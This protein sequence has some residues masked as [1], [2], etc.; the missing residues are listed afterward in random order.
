MPPSTAHF[1]HYDRS[2]VNAKPNGKLNAILGL[3]AGVQL[4]HGLDNPQTCLHCPVRIVFVC[5]GIAKV[6][7]KPVTEILCYVAVKALN[8]IC[9]LFLVGPHNLAKVFGVESGGQ[10]GR[11]NQIAKHHG[12]LTPFGAGE[13]GLKRMG[14]RLTVVRG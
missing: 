12:Q 3:Q 6:N 9:C 4:P 13:A 7:Q 10:F 1:S 8:Y 5:L 14:C 2:G 11:S